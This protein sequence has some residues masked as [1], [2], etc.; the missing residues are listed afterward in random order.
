M[1]GERE[2]I[3]A[4]TTWS[5]TLSGGE[6]PEGKNK[7]DQSS[8]LLDQKGRILLYGKRKEKK[9]RH[10]P[11]LPSH[12]YLSRLEKKG[13]KILPSRLLFFRPRVHSRREEET[14]ERASAGPTLCRTGAEKKKGER[15]W[16][17]ISFFRDRLPSWE[18]GRKRGGKL[19]ALLSSTIR[20]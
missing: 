11:L 3:A 10:R 1:A 19:A 12:Q 6:D 9:L 4:V 7:K 15:A 5:L 8:L 17:L 16:L 13:K 2:G 20:C 14:R 18:D